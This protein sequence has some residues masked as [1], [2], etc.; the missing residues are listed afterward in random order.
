MLFHIFSYWP[1]PWL[2]FS[3]ANLHKVHCCLFAVGMIV[4]SW[5]FFVLGPSLSKFTSTY[6]DSLLL[7]LLLVQHCMSCFLSA[8]LHRLIDAFNVFSAACAVAQVL[9]FV[10]MWC[11]GWLMLFIWTLWMTINKL[12][13]PLIV[14]S[15]NLPQGKLLSWLFFA[16][17]LTCRLHQC[18]TDLLL[19]LYWP[20]P[21][22]NGCKYYF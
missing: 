9:F 6:W 13:F 3:L 22:S 14:F 11:K 7:F 1:F 2:S 17:P 4:C 10:L 12:F 21:C 19:F 16:C 5:C 18:H 15:S 20:L 8:M